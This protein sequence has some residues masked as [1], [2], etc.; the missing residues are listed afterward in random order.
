MIIH[1]SVYVIW[2][3]QFGAGGGDAEYHRYDNSRDTCDWIFKKCKKTKPNLHFLNDIPIY[4][5]IP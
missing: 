2:N 4:Y 1:I 5:S 3:F